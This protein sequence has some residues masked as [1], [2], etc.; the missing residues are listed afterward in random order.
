M[1]LRQQCLYCWKTYSY[2]GTYI[3]HLRRDRKETV[4]FVSAEHLPDGG[5]PIEHDSILLPFVHD[6]HHD[7]FLYPSD[8]DSSD[9]EADS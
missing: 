6:S 5:F 4:V 8:D 3:T 9:I 1:D 2:I 7:P